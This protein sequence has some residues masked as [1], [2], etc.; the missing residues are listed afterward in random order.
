ML[1][2]DLNLQLYLLEGVQLE[3]LKNKHL[4]SGLNLTEKIQ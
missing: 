2:E 3:Q 1:E 4:A